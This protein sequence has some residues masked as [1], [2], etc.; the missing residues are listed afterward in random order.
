M[1]TE[2]LLCSLLLLS[3]TQKSSN[4]DGEINQSYEDKKQGYAGKTDP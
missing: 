2:K 3:V 4:Q 1:P